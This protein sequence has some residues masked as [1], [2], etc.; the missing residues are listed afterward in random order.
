MISPTEAILEKDE[1]DPTEQ[2]VH[3]TVVNPDPKQPEVI[4]M[5]ASA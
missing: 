3:L 4:K 2:T 1:N 5:A